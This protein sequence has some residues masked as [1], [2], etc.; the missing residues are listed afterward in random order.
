V[1]LNIKSLCSSPLERWEPVVLFSTMAHQSV[2]QGAEA[3]RTSRESL[4]SIDIS[5]AEEQRGTLLSHLQT[6]ST[7]VSSTRSEADSVNRTT[8]QSFTPSI[9]GDRKNEPP[10]RKLQH[11][12]LIVYLTL[13]YAIIAIF[14]WS[15]VCVLVY[16]PITTSRY[17]RPQRGHSLA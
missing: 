13:A 7:Q 9:K 10:S 6:D 15:V 4:R 3:P 5:P 8:T 14:A 2:V 11:Y 12:P 17:G 16:R 1:L